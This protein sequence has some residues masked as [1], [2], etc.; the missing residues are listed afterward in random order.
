[1]GARFSVHHHGAGWHLDRTAFDALL[2]D[3]GGT[4]RVTL[5]RRTRVRGAAREDGLWRLCLAD[6]AFLTARFLV[7]ATGASALPGPPPRRP[8]R[9]LRPADRLRPPFEETEER[10]PRSLVEAFA[11]GWWYTAGLPGRSPHSRNCL[12]DADLASHLR[13]GDPAG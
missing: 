6:G 10:D 7:D 9:G 11:D 8:F 2:A 1:V 13:P 3:E 4:A 12:T 5:L